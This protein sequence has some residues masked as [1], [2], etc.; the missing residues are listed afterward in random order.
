MAVW[1]LPFEK[2]RRVSRCSKFVNVWARGGPIGNSNAKDMCEG[3]AVVT[4]KVFENEMNGNFGS[5]LT[6]CAREFDGRLSEQ[7][8]SRQWVPS[9]E[10]GWGREVSALSGTRGQEVVNSLRRNPLLSGTCQYS[11]Q[12][13]DGPPERHKW[14]LL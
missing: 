1:L 12:H 5:N 6:K 11:Q 2:V 10:G 4:H 9:G 13:R 3:R 7:A 14:R 8:R